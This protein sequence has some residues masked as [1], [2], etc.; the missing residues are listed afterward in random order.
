MNRRAAL[1]T[2]AAGVASCRR[3]DDGPSHFRAF[4]MREAQRSL[5]AGVRSKLVDRIGGIEHLLGVVYDPNQEDAIVVGHSATGQAPIELDDFVAAIRAR[6]VHEQWPLVSI[7]KTPETRV[8]GK[9]QIRF[10]GVS[11]CAFADHLL[12]ADVFLKKVALGL[13]PANELPVRSFF[14]LCAEAANNGKWDG[15]ISSRL[16]FYPLNAS[17][18]LREEVAAIR[19]LRIGVRTEVAGENH[20]LARDEVSDQYAA[21][22][23]QHFDAIAVRFPEV[24][25]LKNLFDLVALASGLERFRQAD[26]SYWVNEYPLPRVSI[27]KEF[28]LLRREARISSSA[29]SR[30]LE[31]NG[32]IDTRLLFSRLADG[33]HKAFQQAVLWSR[34]SRNALVWPVPLDKL[35]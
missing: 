10:E 15:R 29:G 4:S 5:A 13:P 24:G 17:L 26:L 21:E 7:D 30:L 19:Q 31:V 34:P 20:D 16:W 23:T 33:D 27:P 12:A 22:L 2:L 35:R 9:Q 25:R 6:L 1:L 14:D 18:L 32:G 28:N 3:P 11:D 8:T